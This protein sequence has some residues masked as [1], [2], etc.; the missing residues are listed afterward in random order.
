M[1]TII[2]RID[3]PIPQF[4]L[5]RYYDFLD[6]LGQ[7]IVFSDKFEIKWAKISLKFW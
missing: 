6:A 2:I 3:T 1:L 4:L 7:Q 5:F